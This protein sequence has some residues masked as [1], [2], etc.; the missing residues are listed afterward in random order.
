MCSIAQFGG[1]PKRMV[2]F[3]QSAGG[4]SVDMYSF[5]YAQDPIVYGLISESGTAA[6]PTGPPTNSS[7]AWWESSHA[8]GCGGI[9]AGESTL[10]CV[11][12]KS[13]QEVTDTVPRRG[14][15]ANIGAGGFGP[16]IDN[17]SVFPDYN[18]RRAEGNFAKIVSPTSPTSTR[19]VFLTH[20][21]Q[22][23]SATQTTKKASTR[24]S[25]KPVEKHYQ[26]ATV[27]QKKTAA[28]LTP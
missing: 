26:P 18:K 17:K 4:A 1:D 20:H 7:A 9:E 15:T 6:N 3:G 27:H 21:S 25:P 16:T 10:A 12:S 28:D 19:I 24:T 2:L 5:A 22:C 23:S 8:L 13:W 11:R 14:V